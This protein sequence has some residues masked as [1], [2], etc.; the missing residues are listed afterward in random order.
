M[1]RLPDLALELKVFTSTILIFAGLALL[2][3][4]AYVLGAH[5]G[6]EEN[7]GL[8]AS[9]IAALYTG[10]GTSSVTLIG[11]AH[12]HLLSL[13]PV[14]AIIGFIFVHSTLPSIWRLALPVLPY[15]AFLADVASWFLTKFVAFGFVY[16][17]IGA[18]VTYFAALG[19]MILV[20]FYDLWLGRRSDA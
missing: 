8:H 6:T 13:L 1:R 14:F 17:V 11:L 15:V 19:L 2:M 18:G 20:S 16:V 5:Q 7:Y 9:E 12:I 10:P 3:S 4:F